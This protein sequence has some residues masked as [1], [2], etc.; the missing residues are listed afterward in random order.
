MLFLD[1]NPNLDL[2]P[3]LYLSLDPVGQ[4]IPGVSDPDQLICTNLF[5]FRVFWTYVHHH[6]QALENG[7]LDVYTI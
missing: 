1:L 3:N 2:D 5:V 4:T 7:V 6:P